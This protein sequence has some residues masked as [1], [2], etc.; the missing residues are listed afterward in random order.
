MSSGLRDVFAAVAPTYER[1]NRILTLGLDRGWRRRAVRRAVEAGGTRWLDVCSGTGETAAALAGKAPAG[2]VV[3][4]VDFCAPMLERVREKNTFNL[5]GPVIRPV[6]ADVT[7]LPFPD[8]SLDLVA[9]S[10]ATRNLNLS[11][12]ILAATFA[13]FR[14]VLRPGGRFVNVETS[15][16][17]LRIV[18]AVFHGFVRLF[19]ERIGARLSGSRA[20]YAYLAATIPRFYDPDA[21]AGILRKAG[22]SRV[23]YERMFFGAAAVHVA[24]R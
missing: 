1:V 22:F 4:A 6:L 17:R 21:L 19:V 18:R 2:A 3:L 5:G 14:R 15:R 11:R 23:S 7:K 10:F 16:P 12:D 8:A 13:E 9:L 24:F 20:G